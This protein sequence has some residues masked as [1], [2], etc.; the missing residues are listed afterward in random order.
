MTKWSGDCG[1]GGHSDSVV[2]EGEECGLKKCHHFVP[3]LELCERDDV[4][5]DWV[6]CGVILADVV[7]SAVI[8]SMVFLFS[9]SVSLLKVVFCDG[10]EVV[11]FCI[12][13]V[14]WSL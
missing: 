2:E 14:S 11:S 4:E 6:E 13:F 8:V 10:G 1:L 3:L 7:L 9:F 5:S 12:F